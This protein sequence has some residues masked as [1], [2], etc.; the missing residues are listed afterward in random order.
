M[1]GLSTRQKKGF[2][3]DHVFEIYPE[4]YILKINKFND[5]AT[6]GLDEWLYYFKHNEVRPGSMGKGLNRVQAKLEF[7]E[8]SASDRAIYLKSLENMVIERDTWRTNREEGKEEG[9]TEATRQGIVRALQSGKLTPTEI[10]DLFAVSLDTVLAIQQEMS[11][12]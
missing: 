4:Y 8:L 10:A 1:L 6:D 11:Q 12:R 2:A 7:D 3:L 5:L 9:R